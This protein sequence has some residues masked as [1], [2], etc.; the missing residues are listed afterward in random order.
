M[1]DEMLDDGHLVACRQVFSAMP[2]LFYVRRR[3]SQHIAFEDTRR[4]THPRMWRIFA[5]M[6]PAIHPDRPA[7]LV[8]VDVFVNRNQRMGDFIAFFPHSYLERTTMNVL[9]HVNLALMLGK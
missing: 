8:R 2:S 3:D 7:L 1:P 4:E 5:G 6:R 9:D